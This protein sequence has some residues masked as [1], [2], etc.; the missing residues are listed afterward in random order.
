MWFSIQGRDGQDILILTVYN[1]SQDNSSGDNTLYT[2]QRAQY[3]NDYHAQSINT[4]IDPYIDPKLCFIADL[5]LLLKESSAKLQDVIITGDFNDVIG[6]SFNSLTK[7]I[8]E[9]DL[10]GVHAFNHGYDYN[11]ATYF[12]GSCR[13]DYVF[14]SCCIIDHVVLFFWL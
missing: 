1:V 10:R 13:L 8:Q 9:F 11:I 14:V 7:L 2:Q 4:P 12:C 3:T 5:R 6:D